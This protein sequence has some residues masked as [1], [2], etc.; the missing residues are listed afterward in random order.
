MI[1]T[2]TQLLADFDALPEAEKH[3]VAVEI[4]HRLPEDGDLPEACMVAM[5]DELFLA[6]DTEEERRAA[7][8]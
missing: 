3:A 6:M 7:N 5:A 2:A 1:A 8:P 4:L